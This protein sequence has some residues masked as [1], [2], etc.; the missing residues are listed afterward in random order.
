MNR[1]PVRVMVPGRSLPEGKIF[2]EAFGILLRCFPSVSLQVYMPAPSIPVGRDNF[3][4]KQSALQIRDKKVPRTAE[5]SLAVYNTKSG[6]VVSG[7]IFPQTVT[8]LP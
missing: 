6:N 4:R 1:Q 8:D 3:L 5:I 7:Q 2:F